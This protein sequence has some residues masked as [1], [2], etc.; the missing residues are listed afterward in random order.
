[1]TEIDKI[2]A[3]TAIENDPDIIFDRTRI[4]WI[5]TKLREILLRIRSDIRTIKQIPSL[6]CIFATGYFG[7]SYSVIGYALIAQLKHYR[8]TWFRTI[9]S[10]LIDR[11]LNII[12]NS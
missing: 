10:K 6:E 1:M 11:D 9:I 12:F 4:Q 7:K 3:Y 5:C 2:P 8:S